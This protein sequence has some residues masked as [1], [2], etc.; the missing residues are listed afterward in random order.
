MC[1]YIYICITGSLC[2][3]AEIDT[4]LYQLYSNKNKIKLKRWT[5]NKKGKWKQRAANFHFLSVKILVIM[6]TCFEEV[7]GMWFNISG[8]NWVT[9]VNVFNVHTLE[10]INKSKSEQEG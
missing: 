4:T 7:V 9:C 10:L 3:I 8:G 6:I 1:V 5:G 2:C